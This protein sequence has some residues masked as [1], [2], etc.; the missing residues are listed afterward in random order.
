MQ[1]NRC[2]HYKSEGEFGLH[3]R[4]GLMV[5]KKCCTVCCEAMKVYDSSKGRPEARRK[6]AHNIG[7]I[8][9]RKEYAKSEYG[10]Q[11]QSK[12]NRKPIRAER[13]R[14]K[15]AT[16]PAF[17]LRCSLT[18]KVGQMLHG[19]YNSQAV[20]SFTEFTDSET[21]MD[22]FALQLTGTMTRENYGDVWHVDHKIAC[23]WFS[24]DEADVRRCWRKL[25]LQPMLGPE[26]QSKGALLPPDDKLLALRSIW[27]AAWQD[28]LPTKEDRIRMYQSIHPRSKVF[29]RLEA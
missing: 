17:S 14:V 29:T 25:N 8:Q 27:P 15:R 9:K 3:N 1:C 7:R 11:V 21:M 13:Q 22:W 16:D 24:A 19:V 6:N 4:K 10:K 12:A 2:K 18:H 23:C 5:R 26:N 20:I 28:T